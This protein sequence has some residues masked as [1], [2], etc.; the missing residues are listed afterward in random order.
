MPLWSQVSRAEV[1]PL[2]TG[3]EHTGQ[4]NG[5]SFSFSNS[6]P[7]RLFTHSVDTR[8]TSEFNSRAVC[9]CYPLRVLLR[10]FLTKFQ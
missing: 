6:V 10:K 8:L 5:A 1:V 9:L 4:I 2:R 7:Y 3:G